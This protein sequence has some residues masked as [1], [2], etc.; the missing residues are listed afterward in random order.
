MT[1]DHNITFRLI[2]FLLK[3]EKII[4]MSHRYIHLKSYLF[5]HRIKCLFII[6]YYRVQ[7]THIYSIITYKTINVLLDFNS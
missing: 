5:N 2:F 1:H 6:V 3:V 4:G 7:Y